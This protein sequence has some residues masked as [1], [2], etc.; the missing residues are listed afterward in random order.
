[1][2]AV[3]RVL[4]ALGAVLLLVVIAIAWAPAT[5]AAHGVL[6]AS[7]GVLTLADATGRLVDGRG[8]LVDSGH[9]VSVPVA[10]TVDAG[11]LLAGTLVV[12]LGR[13]PGDRVRGIVH[14]T[15]DAIQF[16]ATD[17]TLPAAFASAW[18]P[19]VP[20]IDFGGDLRLTAAAWRIG[21]GPRGDARAYW[22]PAR[23]ADARG[24]TLDFGAVTA[25]I[26]TRG[27]TTVAALSS[28]GGDTAIGGT[29][30]VSVARV[31]ADLTLTP[32]DAMP[33]PL[34]SAISGAGSPAP[35][36]GTRFAYHGTLVPRAR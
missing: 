7:G 10:W 22:T 35:A 20:A 11:A 9:R 4:A 24:Q 36:G 30:G 29:L 3:L 14:V 6:E 8:R 27:D 16:D 5:L 28:A 2:A 26:E 25:S 13:D 19:P 21:A 31:D 23:V 32:R 34:L 1:M 17:I 18:L 33:A 15:R 12:H